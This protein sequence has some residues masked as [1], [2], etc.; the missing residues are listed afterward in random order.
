[1]KK[2]VKKWAIAAGVRAL[3]TAAQTAIA[4]IGVSALMSEV[5]WIAV[6]SSSLLAAVLSLVTSLKG[7][8]ELEGLE[9]KED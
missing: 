2:K 9:G 3:R 7:L 5:D 1:M 8:P 4:V 6:G